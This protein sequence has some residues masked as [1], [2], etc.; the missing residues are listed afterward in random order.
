MSGNDRKG[1]FLGATAGA[2]A[3]GLA[4]ASCATTET[5]TKKPAT[6]PQD[7]VEQS[8]PGVL[9]Q[10]FHPPFA[11]PIDPEKGKKKTESTEHDGFGAPQPD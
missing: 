3:L 10:P 9:R 6:A 1:G 2:V 5:A 7:T 11:S 4:L 8:Q